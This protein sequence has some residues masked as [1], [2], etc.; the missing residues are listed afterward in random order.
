MLS[1]KSLEQWLVLHFPVV[2]LQ[3]IIFVCLIWSTGEH[4]ESCLFNCSNGSCQQHSCNVCLHSC[5]EPKISSCQQ[6]QCHSGAFCY[7]ER[8]PQCQC[9]PGYRQQDD[10]TSFS[11]TCPVC[12]DSCHGFCQNNGV[13]MHPDDQDSNPLCS[14]SGVFTGLRCDLT[15]TS[16]N[17]EG[18]S[19]F[20]CYYSLRDLNLLLLLLDVIGEGIAY[21]YRHRLHST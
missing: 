19:R 2:T 15:C 17:R 4:C 3:V 11:G 12:I 16:C 7:F 20:Y 14:C 21:A 18:T 6:R 13:C 9:P 8:T 1:V 10:C 5:T